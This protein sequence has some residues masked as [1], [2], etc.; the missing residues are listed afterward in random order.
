MLLAN[1]IMEGAISTGLHCNGAKYDHENGSVIID[2][3]SVEALNTIYENTFYIPNE[4]AIK[5]TMEGTN[6]TE[7]SYNS[8]MEGAFSNAWEKIKTFFINLKEKI[9]VFIHNIKRYLDKIFM[10]D[11]DWVIKYE[12]DIKDIDISK[13]KDYEV[14]LYKYTLDDIDVDNINN[15]IDTI[16]TLAESTTNRLKSLSNSTGTKSKDNISDMKDS[17]DSVY[18][19]TLKDIGISDDDE[20]DKGLWSR[21][22]NGAMDETD[23][24]DV[25]VG[26]N[27]NNFISTIKDSSK[28]LSFCDKYASKTSSTYDK[29]IK[30][31]SKSDSEFKGK[32]NE[33]ECLEVLRAL[34]SSL[35]KLQ[36]LNNKSI[37]YMK[38]AVVERNK[39]YRK[40]LAGIF[41]Y[42]RKHKN[43]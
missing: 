25:K 39:E 18:T 16:T 5:A 36:S 20:L 23:K 33:S 11:R 2:M 12:K 22:R 42:S 29:C 3:E 43:V 1:A 21:Y 19:R 35:S 13:M 30:L 17:C 7:S 4:C 28:V 38:N 31:V 34:S 27:V 15:G 6:I 41:T 40:A 10:D 8:V 26:A 37:S 24:E 9:K 32:A 14:R